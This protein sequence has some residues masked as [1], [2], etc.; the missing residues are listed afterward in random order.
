MTDT[1]RRVVVQYT[2]RADA[3][4]ENQDLVEAVFAELAER[5]PIG[6]SYATFRLDDGVTFV[7]VASN[8]R[9]DGSNPLD[10]VEAFKLFGQG[11]ASR[12]EVAPVVR[13]AT[14]VGSFGFG[15]TGEGTR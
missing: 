3:A 9:A 13:E 8:E 7:H 5:R 6:L 10:E 2:T 4:D 14:L 12:C 15:S 1:P 11:V